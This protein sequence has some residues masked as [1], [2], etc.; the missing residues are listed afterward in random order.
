MPRTTV[1]SAAEPPICRKASMRA[2]SVMTWKLIERRALT[3][4]KRAALAS[5]QP[6]MAIATAS[7]TRGRKAPAWASSVRRLSRARSI[8][9][10]PF[11]SV[12][13]R[14]QDALQRQGHPVRP[15]GQFVA[16]FVERLFEHEQGEQAARRGPL[17]I[18]PGAAGGGRRRI[19]V[20]EGGVDH[21]APGGGLRGQ[22]LGLLG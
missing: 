10:M 3:T 21:R 8:V 20:D 2:R 16:Q 15:V 14:R 4:V 6:A 7:S 13:E 12:A 5:S 1:V 22:R 18:E 19:A 11:S 9:S 17:A